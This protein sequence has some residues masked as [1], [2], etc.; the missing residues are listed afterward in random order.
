M[1]RISGIDIPRDKR[2]IASLR[3]IH[4]IGAKRAED[5][6]VDLKI[7]PSTRVSNLTNDEVAQIR[8]YIEANFRVEGDLRRDVSQNIRRKTEI[9]TYQG[10]RHR[11]GLPVRGQRLTPMQELEKVLD[12]LLQGKRK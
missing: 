5:I 10:L 1:A 4:G 6:C 9:G 12:L 8:K 3:Y 2:V 7:D 11:M